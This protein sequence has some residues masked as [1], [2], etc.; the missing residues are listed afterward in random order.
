MNTEPNDRDRSVS[1]LI[2]EVHALLLFCQ[3]VANRHDDP[4][5]IDAAL[6]AIEQKGLAQIESTLVMDA[7]IDGFQFAMASLRKSARARTGK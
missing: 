1:F 4:G 7:T 3:I 6:E 2:G 5:M